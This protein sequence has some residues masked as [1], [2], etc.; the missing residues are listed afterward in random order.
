MIR[1]SYPENFE[2]IAHQGAA[3]SH[4]DSSKLAKNADFDLEYHLNRVWSIFSEERIR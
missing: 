4:V 2:K 1:E 3:Q